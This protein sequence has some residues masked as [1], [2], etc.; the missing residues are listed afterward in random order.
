MV[1]FPNAKINLG[2]NI[3]SR[4]EDGY[5]NIETVFFPVP[6]FD[7]LEV[8]ESVLPSDKRVNL[9]L[10]GMPDDGRPNLVEKA[11]SKLASRYD[12]P[13]VDVYLKKNIPFAAGLGGGSAD[14]AFMLK[15]LAGKYSLPV[16]P[17][18]LHRFASEIGADCPFFLYNKPLYACGTGTELSA[19]SVDLDG[20]FMAIIKPSVAVS[21]A[22]AYSGVTPS[23][24]GYDIKDVLVMP[25]CSWRGVLKNDFE[26]SLFIKYPLLRNIKE[27]LYGL[28]AVYAS[29]SG[30]GSAIFG[31][32]EDGSG[33]EYAFSGREA[34]ESVSVFR[35][36]SSVLCR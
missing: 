16:T 3:V 29:M 5:H 12:L 19:A 24:P 34:I 30:S 33:I 31:I 15:L 8:T 10:Y 4:R 11:Y 25:P 13:P 18:E 27:E 17:S 1:V 36:D 32:F 20:L 28:G 6:V 7:V 9:H 21:T 35:I 26:E 14:A 2:L 22:E 23:E